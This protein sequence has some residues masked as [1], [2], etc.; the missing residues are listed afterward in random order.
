MI[1]IINI[2]DYMKK[3]LVCVDKDK[4]IVAAAKIM[5]KKNVGSLLVMY[6]KK[7]IGILTQTDVLKRVVAKDKDLNTTKVKD[8]M[9]KKLITAPLESTFTK[10]TGIMH[11]YR[12]K[13]IAITKNKKVVGVITSTDI[14]KLMSGKR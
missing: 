5:S 9:T 8:V 10:I 7:P 6:K 2:K 14:I 3:S 1:N 4:G 11:K 12:I 13:H